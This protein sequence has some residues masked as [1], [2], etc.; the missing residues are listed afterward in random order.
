MNDKNITYKINIPQKNK[1]IL[2]EFNENLLS[3]LKK[4]SIPIASSC[5][6]DGICTK[7]FVFIKFHDQNLNLSY[8]D[9][10]FKNK[11]PE[12]EFEIQQK[13]KNKIPN[14]ARLSC[15]INIK[16]DLTITTNYW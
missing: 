14:S 4:N 9:K 8:E 11:Y 10:N 6:G 2:A 15:M 5:D 12:L 1:I 7:C 16:S 3:L 13:V